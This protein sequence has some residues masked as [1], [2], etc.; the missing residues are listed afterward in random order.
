MDSLGIDI[1][2]ISR[3]KAAVR[4]WGDVFLKRVYT[5]EEQRL[6]RGKYP[7]L[8]AR[9]AAKEAVIKALDA[10]NCGVSLRDIEVLS[11][12]SGKPEVSLQGRAKIRADEM[13]L[14]EIS[15]SLSHSRDNAVACV[16]GK[17]AK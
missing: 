9:F 2:E 8:A 11:A 4:R 15:I 17:S 6:Y 14:R 3:I 5:D 16:Y 1:V 7:S 10:A 12:G 13:G